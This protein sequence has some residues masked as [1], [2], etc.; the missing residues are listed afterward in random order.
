MTPSHIKIASMVAVVVATFTAGMSVG[1]KFVGFPRGYE[2]GV[3]AAGVIND[4][5]NDVAVNTMRGKQAC[6]AEVVKVNTEVDRQKEENRKILIDDR[7]ATTVAV[8]RVEKAAAVAVASATKTQIQIA[9][10]RN[11]IGKIKDACVSAGVP[12]DFFI[13]LNRALGGEADPLRSA[14]ASQVP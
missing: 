6:V 8:E 13:V 2:A 9:E 10:A 7:A 14:P 12:A 5:L 11:E 1:W 4:A 3:A